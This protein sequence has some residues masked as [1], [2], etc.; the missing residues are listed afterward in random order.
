MF[1]FRDE[2]SD[3]GLESMGDCTANGIEAVIKEYGISEDAYNVFGRA[4]AGTLG[5]EW[6]E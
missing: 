2:L 3:E 1:D 5:E 6:P 4:F